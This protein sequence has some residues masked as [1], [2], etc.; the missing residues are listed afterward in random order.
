MDIKHSSLSPDN[1]SW[2]I[3]NPI[4]R[5]E[6]HNRMSTAW[7][8]NLTTRYFYRDGASDAANNAVVRI[9]SDQPGIIRAQIKVSPKKTYSTIITFPSLSVN[10]FN[11]LLHEYI[12]SPEELE[13][14]EQGDC[15]LLESRISS[16]SNFTLM[17]LA[18]Y[19]Y[20][21]AECSCAR[22]AYFCRHAISALCVLVQAVSDNFLL[23]FSYCGIPI[24]YV[25]KA[26]QAKRTEL[27]E[28][29]DKASQVDSAFC[30]RFW[31]DDNAAFKNI[32]KKIAPPQTDAAAMLK[33][34]KIPIQINKK[35]ADTFFQEIYHVAGSSALK[36][37]QGGEEKQ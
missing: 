7:S 25:E 34:G 28:A 15:F 8:N 9:E 18:R 14:L 21:Q 6:L 10:M 4:C 22:H 5:F 23:Y 1:F 32:E 29:L 12:T 33:L 3:D 24:E 30:A 13:Q 31:G 37:L 17:P 26:I 2:S 36:M 20:V 11:K 27:Q 16:R 35:A 19:E